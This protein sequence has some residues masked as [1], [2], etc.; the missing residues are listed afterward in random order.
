A[1]RLRCFRSG[2]CYSGRLGRFGSREGHLDGGRRGIPDWREQR[3]W[4]VCRSLRLLLDCERE[5]A[6]F[7]GDLAYVALGD[8][9][10]QVLD[11][12]Q[13]HVRSLRIIWVTASR[14]RYTSQYVCRLEGRRP[15]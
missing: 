14:A 9:V 8:H 4:I 13:I 5:I 11:Q 15:R 2:W 10:E 6:F 3:L 1:V 12:L 7:D